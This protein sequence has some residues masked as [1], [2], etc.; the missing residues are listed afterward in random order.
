MEFYNFYQLSALFSSFFTKG[1][2]QT[3]TLGVLVGGGLWILFF[4]LQG[5]GLCTMARRRG[6]KHKAL[7]FIPFANIYYMGKLAGECGFFGHKMK[8]AGIY[9]MIAQIFATLVAVAYVLSEWYLY[10][11]HGV[12]QSETGVGVVTSIPYWSGLTGFSLTVSKF[13]DYG[14]F[15][16][17]IFNLISQLLMIVLLIGLYKKYSPRNYFG[18]GMLT[19]F[20]PIARF[21]AVFALRNR[22]AVDFEAYM[23]RRREEYIRR[24]QQYYNQYGNPYNRPYGGSPYGMGGYGNPNPNPNPA[25][26]AEEPFG[27]FSSDR[28]GNTGGEEKDE[29]SD[30]F[31][32]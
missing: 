29:N 11:Y 4:I 1:E 23:R 16:I 9:A 18:L 3:I 7:A 8:N 22:E 5:I 6:I 14:G 13:Y 24:Q 30:G 28:K 27:E 19:F 25:P 10:F 20:F 21:I 15:F 2:V 31:F 32:D 26:P 17:S 12:P